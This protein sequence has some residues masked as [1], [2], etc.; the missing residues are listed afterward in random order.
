MWYC[1]ERDEQGSMQER[2]D[3]VVDDILT[4]VPLR[5]YLSLLA[6][7]LTVPTIYPSYSLAMFGHQQLTGIESVRLSA[8]LPDAHGDVSSGRYLVGT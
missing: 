1:L 6:L 2:N 3:V 7:H 8:C 5:F 4:S